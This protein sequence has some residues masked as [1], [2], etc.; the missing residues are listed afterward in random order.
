MCR[1][2]FISMRHPTDLLAHKS[3]GSEFLARTQG[4]WRA[5]H[6]CW[7]IGDPV[8]LRSVRTQPGT[9]RLGLG[10]P[11]ASPLGQFPFLLEAGKHAVEVVLLDTHLRR[12]LGD[13]DAWLPLHERQ[14]L[15]CAGAAAFAAS[16][17]TFPGGRGGFAATARRTAYF[18]GARGTAHFFRT[19]YFFGARRTAHFF[20]AR[21]TAYFFGARRTT[22]FFRAAWFFASRFGHR[23]CATDGATRASR[24]TAARSCSGGGGSRSAY[25]GQGRSGGLEAVELI[26]QRL[27][28]LQSIGD[29]S[30]LLVKEVGHDSILFTSVNVT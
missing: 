7:P 13:R 3:D 9:P 14:R 28:L 8:D 24:S 1:A 25:A 30:A 22:D 12:Q 6:A 18:F 23:A 10:V 15:R 17:T 20:R 11:A 4:A 21:G 5:S 29:L 19:A 27:E 16:G 26:H 2:L